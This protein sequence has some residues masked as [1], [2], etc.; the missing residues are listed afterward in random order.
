MLYFAYG[1]NMCTGRLRARVS[2][3]EVVAVAQLFRHRFAYEK[4]SDDGSSKG[5]ASETGQDTD[6]VWGV[7]FEIDAAQKQILDQAEGLG[8][9]YAE[10]QVTVRDHA[11]QAY[12]CV[13]YYA[14]PSHIVADRPYGWYQRFVVEGARQHALPPEYIDQHLAVP[15]GK[16]DPDTQRDVRKR[17]IAC[18]TPSGSDSVKPSDTAAVGSQR[19]MKHRALLII[20]WF[21]VLAVFN[22]LS[23]R[24]ENAGNTPVYIFLKSLGEATSPV[25]LLLSVVVVLGIALSKRKPL[26]DR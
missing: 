7:V 20:G 17:R 24:T 22:I 9:G 4:R 1:S 16:P 2:S 25:E 12:A 21:L 5:N 13:M 6:F 26:E 15:V 3:A 18:E 10:K 14:Q 19:G 11:Q 23:H 8:H